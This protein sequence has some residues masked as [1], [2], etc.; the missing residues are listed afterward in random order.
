MN[1]VHVCAERACVCGVC[2]FP[3]RWCLRQ[4]CL[5]LSPPQ[6]YA[7]P[8]TLLKINT[9]SW[10]HKQFLLWTLICLRILYH[11]E[12]RSTKWNAQRGICL[13][14]AP[15]WNMIPYSPF[16]TLVIDTASL[17]HWHCVH[18]CCMRWCKSSWCPQMGRGMTTCHNS[19]T[20]S[21]SLELYVLTIPIPFSLSLL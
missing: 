7:F 19:L 6:L 9:S 21:S 8:F 17:L 3:L 16:L 11:S 20:L 12:T 18:G 15:C 5:S 2:N 10:W 1:S 14:L 13:Q 4:V